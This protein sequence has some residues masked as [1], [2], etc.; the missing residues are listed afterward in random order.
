MRGLCPFSN[1]DHYLGVYVNKQKVEMTNLICSLL[2]C[3][4]FNNLLDS[5]Q[6]THKKPNECALFKLSNC[7]YRFITYFGERKR[8]VA[9]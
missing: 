9:A 7:L 3:W 2:L 6:L 4:Q 8:A 1:I 5:A